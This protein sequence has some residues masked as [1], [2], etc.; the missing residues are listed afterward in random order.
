M[1]VTGHEP[2]RK[3]YS[4]G[5]CAVALL[6]LLLFEV[7]LIAA[8]SLEYC[9]VDTAKVEAKSASISAHRVLFQKEDTVVMKKKTTVKEY[10]MIRGNFISS[11]YSS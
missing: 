4:F 11:L 7:N 2:T 6:L 1:S 8:V 9:P 10:K 3:C 5:D